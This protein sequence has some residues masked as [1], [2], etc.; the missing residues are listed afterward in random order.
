MQS[1]ET[2][3]RAA[4]RSVRRLASKAPAVLSILL[5][6][7]AIAQPT[8]EAYVLWLETEPCLSGES[9]TVRVLLEVPEGSPPV[10]GWSFGVCHDPRKLA[11]E[12]PVAGSALGESDCLPPGAQIEETTTGDLGFRQHVIFS[13]AGDCGLA[14]GCPYELAV[15][16]YSCLDATGVRGAVGF[17]DSVD[18]GAPGPAPSILIGTETITPRVRRTSRSCGSK[19][20]IAED[21]DDGTVDGNL[22]GS[23]Q[24]LELTAGDPSS[25]ALSLTQGLDDQLGYLWFNPSF[26]L[27]ERRTEISFDFFVRD[28]TSAEPA[29]GFSVILQ[30]GS[31]TALLGGGGGNLATCFNSEVGFISVSVDIWDNGDNDPESACDDDTSRTCHIEVN[32]NSCPESDA[33]LQTNVDFGV[34]IPDLA[35][36]GNEL[37]PV[38]VTIAVNG[39]QSVEVSVQTDGAPAFGVA[40]LQVLNVPL[41][42]LPPPE[43]VIL[44]LGGSTGGANAD[45]ILNNIELEDVPV[46]IID[47]FLRG[48]TDGSGAVDLSDG[49]SLLNHLFLGGPAPTC[50][51]AADTTDEGSLSLTGAIFLF[52]HLFLGGPSPPP[53]NACGFGDPTFDVFQ[54]CDYPACD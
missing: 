36:L 5:S 13:S 54:Q 47:D 29:D 20:L 33:S 9:A 1:M 48:D 12:R 42:P 26:Q 19:L 21:F 18:V 46:L 30:Y 43:L 50:P 44:G 38:H 8:P 2:I 49:I 10:S 32:Q 16:T 39:I 34:E 14:P 40:A 22:L 28:G 35:P 25:R 6:T 51:D 11:L 53:P 24:I 37:I 7:T 3:E 31:D 27:A 17:C 52:S 23:A 41:L 45:T 15:A 4:P